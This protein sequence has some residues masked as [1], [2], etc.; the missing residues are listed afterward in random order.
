MKK[1]PVYLHVYTK[2]FQHLQMQMYTMR[3]LWHGLAKLKLIFFLNKLMKYLP[4]EIALKFCEKL[5]CYVIL[6]IPCY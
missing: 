4:I 1:I 3:L 2:L 5:L 6:L